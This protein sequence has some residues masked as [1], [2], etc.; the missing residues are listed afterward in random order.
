MTPR[1]KRILASYF[2]CIYLFIVFALYAAFIGTL[3]WAV[4]Q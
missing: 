3:V 1:N 4:L 2:E